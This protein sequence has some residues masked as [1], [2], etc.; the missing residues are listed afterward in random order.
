MSICFYCQV[1]QMMGIQGRPTLP[2]PRFPVS[3]IAGLTNGLLKDKWWLYNPP[4]ISLSFPGGE[5][6]IG[7]VPV[8]PLYSHEISATPALEAWN[9]CLRTIEIFKTPRKTTVDGKNPGAENQNHGELWEKKRSSRKTNSSPLKNAG[10]KTSLSF[11][12]GLFWQVTCVHFLRGVSQIFCSLGF[13][14]C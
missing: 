4:H 12:N 2:M 3:E 7:V 5:V 14:M 13:H 11:W 9:H 8:V 10:W 6:G 1:L